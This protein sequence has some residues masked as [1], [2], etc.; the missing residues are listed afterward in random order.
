MSAS[1][2]DSH[3]VES[4]GMAR[5][6]LLLNSNYYMTNS[7]RTDFEKFDWLIVNL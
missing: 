5:A 7:S 1:S 2:G 6:T 4:P 3:N